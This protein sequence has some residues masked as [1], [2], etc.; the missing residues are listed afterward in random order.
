MLGGFF[1]SIESFRNF[2]QLIFIFYWNRFPL[3]DA[4]LSK[5]RMLSGLLQ[6][7]TETAKVQNFG[8]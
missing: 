2:K 7:I 4:F 6:K 3:D 5:Q 1:V 8:M